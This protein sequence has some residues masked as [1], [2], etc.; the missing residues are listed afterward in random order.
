[1][2]SDDSVAE[3][4]HRFSPFIGG[5]ESEEMLI[6]QAFCASARAIPFKNGENGRNGRVMF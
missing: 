1:L 4:R 3:R 6:S 2:L 5:R